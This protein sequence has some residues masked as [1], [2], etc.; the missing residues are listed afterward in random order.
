MMKISRMKQK[1]IEIISGKNIYYLFSIILEESIEQINCNRKQ[2]LYNVIWN[3]NENRQ[4]ITLS[5][6]VSNILKM[7]T[8]FF[9]K[10]IKILLNK[11]AL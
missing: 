11:H 9:T 7:I 8:Y 1:I 3:E 10:L 6:Q 2:Q 4:L 5:S